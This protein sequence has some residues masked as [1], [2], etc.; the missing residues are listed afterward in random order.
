M[1]KTK[2]GYWVWPP[3][4]RR[5]I[6]TTII[7]PLRVRHRQKLSAPNW[8]G[9]RRICSVR[10]TEPWLWDLKAARRQLIKNFL[11]KEWFDGF[12]RLAS[13]NANFDVRIKNLEFWDSLSLMPPADFHNASLQNESSPNSKLHALFF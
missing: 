6:A 7:S 13:S 8:V 5:P 3:I 2:R 11:T 1:K 9:T 4:Y 10:E 12:I